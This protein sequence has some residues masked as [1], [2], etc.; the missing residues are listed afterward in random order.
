MDSHLNTQ[1]V[2]GRGDGGRQGGPGNSAGYCKA[3]GSF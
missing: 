2:E 1:S 3:R